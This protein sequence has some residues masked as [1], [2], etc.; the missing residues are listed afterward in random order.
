MS[1]RIQPT[2]DLA[3]RLDFETLISGLSA[4]LVSASEDALQA[5]VEEA[6]GRVIR[7][8]GADRGGILAV[9]PDR[10]SLH[11]IHAWYA[12]TL[13]DRVSRDIDLAGLFPYGH[14]LVV[15]RRQPFVVDSYDDVPQEASVDR[16]SHRAMGVRS[17]LNIPIAVGADLR[18]VMN[19]DAIHQE[20]RW[21]P[22]YVPRLQLLG[23][24]FANAIERKRIHDA[25]R[26]SE[27]RLALATI[28]AGAGPWDLDMS[29]GRIWA[30]PA[31]KELYG[32]P[33]DQDVTFEM[34]LAVVHPEDRERVR[35]RV[36]RALTSASEFADEYR[37][38]LPEG[39]LRWIAARGRVQAEGTAPPHRV[40]GISQDVTP[41]KHAEEALAAAHQEVLRLREHLERENTYLRQE[42]TSRKERS[43]IVGRSDAVRR[44]LEEID[45]V[46][47]TN[48]TV[49]LLGETGTGKELVA[50]AIHGASPRRDRVMVR[51]NCAAIP[52][53]LIESEL[54]GR[55]RGAYTGALSK[56]AGRF[57]LADGSTI[58][59]DEIGDLPLDIQAKLLRV[60]QERQV[61]RLGSP[62]PIPVDL[63]IIAATNRDL[64]RDVR[65]GRFREDLFYR[66]NVFPVRV[67]PLRDRPEDIPLLVDA[68]IHELAGLMGKRIE[69]VS[70][71][72]LDALAL[73]AWPGN[74]R[75]LRN[76]VERAMILAT[77][78]VLEIEI[79]DGGRPSPEAPPLPRAAA[80]RLDRAELLRVLQQTGWRVRGKKGAAVLLGLKPTT[81]E[82]RI[83]RFGIKRP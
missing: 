43:R 82:Y 57:E 23:E 55:E 14:G 63:R 11:L 35:N 59:L 51:V 7:F 38:V 81:L 13:R 5:T 29:T 44:M 21:P 73:Y 10:R 22:S 15:E 48:A 9:S 6:L 40:M 54:F 18:Y 52:V 33:R 65:D 79:P 77:G 4:K 26:D 72:S 30:T 53:T 36:M 75:E 27:A 50:D 56:Q 39:D 58:F 31:A 47:P 20:V 64:D 69:R 34:F 76:A 66:L 67:P 74:V 46:A 71:A 3:S 32:V 42:V 80:G 8:F 68:L 28:S 25:L 12:E 41:R 19:I 1:P 78:P 62:R 49:L 24:V 2:P 61:E 83:A 60:L 70:R 16:A 37:V 17:T 45:K